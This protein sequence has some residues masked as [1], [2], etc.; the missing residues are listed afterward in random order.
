MF[1][2]IFV[3]C[4]KNF[5]FK[6]MKLTSRKKFISFLPDI[7]LRWKNPIDFETTGRKLRIRRRGSGS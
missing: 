5:N 2:N 1:F 6:V 4:Y 3:H 7:I